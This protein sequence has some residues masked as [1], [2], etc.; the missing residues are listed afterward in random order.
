MHD[1]LVFLFDTCI[2]FIQELIQMNSNVFKIYQPTLHVHVAVKTKKER[3]FLLKIVFDYA[4]WQNFL[5]Y[6]DYLLYDST[7]NVYRYTFE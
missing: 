6:S 7:G 2:N 3:K 1:Y 4:L 5:Y